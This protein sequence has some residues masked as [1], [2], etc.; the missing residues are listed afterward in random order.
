VIGVVVLE[1]GR[2]LVAPLPAGALDSG[3]AKGQA[4]ARS[5]DAPADRPPAGTR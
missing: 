1:K 3:S 4:A 5:G 2:P